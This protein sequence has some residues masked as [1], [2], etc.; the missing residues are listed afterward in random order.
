MN[1]A[2]NIFHSNSMHVSWLA[3]ARG[4][5]HTRPSAW[6]VGNTQSRIARLPSS[7]LPP[8][9]SRELLHTGH[10]AILH[11]MH[12]GKGRGSGL[13][14]LADDG[15][16]GRVNGVDGA[17]ALGVYKLAVDEELLG[18]LNLHVIDVHDDGVVLHLTTGVATTR[19][20]NHGLAELEEGG[21]HEYVQ[22][23]HL[24]VEAV[25]HL[26]HQPVKT[27]TE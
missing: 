25:L 20:E 10:R 9:R 18:E 21:G 5:G 17:A 14:Y 4:R 2:D 24:Q 15:L 16:V 19:F 6:E 11:V 8:R 27:N 12:V 13:S 26:L 3:G 22:S 1:C 23:L 7:C